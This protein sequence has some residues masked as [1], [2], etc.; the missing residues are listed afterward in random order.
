MNL[1]K[2]YRNGKLYAIINPNSELQVG[3][4]WVPAYIYICITDG[5]YKQ[6]SRTVCEFNMKF[7]QVTEVD[8]N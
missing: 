5:D 1:Y 3:G 7:T 8:Y 4:V 6:Y 2:H